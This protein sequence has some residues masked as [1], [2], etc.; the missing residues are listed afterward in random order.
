MDWIDDEDSSKCESSSDDGSISKSVSKKSKTKKPTKERK[1]S[2]SAA[3]EARKSPSTVFTTANETV[4]KGKE[5]T[6]QSTN[7]EPAIRLPS[8]GVDKRRKDLKEIG[9][10]KAAAM[11]EPQMTTTKQSIHSVLHKDKEKTHAKEKEKEL[12][13]PPNQSLEKVKEKTKN[14]E[15]EPTKDKEQVMIDLESSKSKEPPAL[16]A[17]T[18]SKDVN[19]VEKSADL[20]ATA[21]SIQKPVSTFSSSSS[22]FGDS[23]N[24]SG[25]LSLSTLKIKRKADTDD[26]EDCAEISPSSNASKADQP[27]E[28]P[29]YFCKGTRKLSTCTFAPHING[30]LVRKGK[31]KQK[32]N[33][34]SSTFGKERMSSYDDDDQDLEW[35]KSKDKLCFYCR[36]IRKSHNCRNPRHIDGFEIINND[37]SSKI[38]M[39]QQMSD[40]CPDC[41]SHRKSAFC[42]RSDHVDGHQYPYVPPPP[43]ASAAS[44]SSSSAALNAVA[45]SSADAFDQSK[46]E[47]L[48]HA[49]ERE[50]A[51][52]KQHQ[53]A[54]PPISRI[55]STDSDV[56]SLG[57]LTSWSPSVNAFS[58]TTSSSTSNLSGYSVHSS[59]RSKTVA[60]TSIV[61]ETPLLH[62]FEP[63]G[64]SAM[65]TKSA[66][67]G[68]SVDYSKVSDEFTFFP[69]RLKTTKIKFADEMGHVLRFVASF[70]S[71][72]T[73]S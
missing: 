58:S 30:K 14:I 56:E 46:R 59:S 66:L 51:R 39:H 36:S 15:K 67:K 54:P 48:M 72:A 16:K 11:K 24:Q 60:A 22:V 45:S 23:H 63:P 19:K 20:D 4:S 33:H 43:K 8:I 37:N 2:P 34:F 32:T 64:R 62:R 26:E 52:Y 40:F 27:R 55:S 68:I 41:R 38:L 31:K 9:A 49:E 35:S 10:A 18:A 13:I 12:M 70:S 5:K 61:P 17:A 47:K 53:S 50:L 42:K 29:C 6:S 57:K 71:S 69:N 44:S 28:V 25:G 3:A 7:A 21:P 1:K 65:P 73:D